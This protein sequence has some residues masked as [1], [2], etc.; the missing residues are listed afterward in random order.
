M[1]LEAILQK[2]IDEAEGIQSSVLNLDGIEKGIL[3]NNKARIQIIDNPLIYAAYNFLDN[4]YVFSKKAVNDLL[5]FIR[6]GYKHTKN[7]ARVLLAIGEEVAHSIKLRLN[8]SARD[9]LLKPIISIK[10][11]IERINL[12]EY[13]G[14]LG[15]LL[16]ANYKGITK[17]N[18]LW[19]RI[20]NYTIEIITKPFEF[21]SHYFGYKK[22]EEDFQKYGNSAFNKNAL[23][24][25]NTSLIRI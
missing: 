7:S 15:A 17:S 12:E 6:S 20:R 19:S 8:K 2:H 11:Y 18:Y 22:A 13:F 16:Y 5:D 10:D 24:N 14:R 3:T 23:Y 21:F 1:G 25:N 4:N 9:Y